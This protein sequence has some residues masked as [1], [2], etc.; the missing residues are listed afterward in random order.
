MKFKDIENKL[1]N[2]QSNAPRPNVY[3]RAKKAPIN[4]LLSAPVRVFQ[5]KFA[6]QMLAIVFI[7]LLVA[8]F[9]TV[10]M[11]ALPKNQGADEPSYVHIAI[12]KDGKT[13][14]YGFVIR[15]NKVDF[16]CLE[17]DGNGSSTTKLFVDGQ[18]VENAISAVYQSNSGDKA[19][20]CV[21]C[22]DSHTT[23]RAWRLTQEALLNVGVAVERDFNTVAQKT[24]LIE[25]VRDLGADVN[26]ETPFRLILDAYINSL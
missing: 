26:G 17:S 1:K 23:D 19:Y 20:V 18:T 3:E 21:L 14:Q 16:A 25:F 10:T 22:D 11:V 12:E 15:D 5:K 7:L 13:L 6:V 2:E 8:I 24:H 4:K 9:A